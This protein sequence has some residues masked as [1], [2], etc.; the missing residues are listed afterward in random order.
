MTDPLVS[1][2]VATLNSERHLPECLDAVLAQDWPRERM[3]ILIVDAGS[4]DRTR[5]IARERGVD[6]VLDNPRR[7][8]EAG[9]AVGLRAAHGELVCSVDSDNIVVGS[10]WLRRMVK[11]FADPEVIGSEVARFHYRRE[12]GLINRWHALTGVTD[13]MTIYLGNYARDSLVTGAW[14]GLPHDSELREGWERVT[15]RRGAVP[16]LGANGFVLRR[17]AALKAVPV[18]D[19]HFDLDYVH[20]LVAAG[21]PVF[22]RV[23]AAVRHYFCDGPRQFVRKTRRR[24]EDFFFFRHEGRRS[25]PWMQRR[26]LAAAVEFAVCTVLVLPTLLD[27]ARG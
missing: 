6:R 1:I 13:P 26:R 27:A 3:E 16:V 5:E 9:K 14:T 10:D 17:A 2:V 24:A 11:P 8:A 19:Y 12:D 21:H 15:L 7:T 25:Y 4:T 20:E 22:G 23:D 18:G